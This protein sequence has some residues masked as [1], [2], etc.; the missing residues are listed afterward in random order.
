MWPEA[1]SAELAALLAAA[2]EVVGAAFRWIAV[3]FAF[4]R[5][6]AVAEGAEGLVA[7]AAQVELSV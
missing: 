6:A 4:L 7:V 1:A 5:V 3:S 2:G